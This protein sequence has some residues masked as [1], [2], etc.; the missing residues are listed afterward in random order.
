VDKYW[1][2]LETR[3][4]VKDEDVGKEKDG[5]VVDRITRTAARMNSRSSNVNLS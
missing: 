4:I 1:R 5:A 2:P 3:S